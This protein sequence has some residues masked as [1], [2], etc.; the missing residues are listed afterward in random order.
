MKI[1]ILKIRK[2]AFFK[3]VIL[4]IDKLLRMGF[5]TFSGIISP[6]TANPS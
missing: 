2:F 5:Q 1:T 6:K 4:F 3:I